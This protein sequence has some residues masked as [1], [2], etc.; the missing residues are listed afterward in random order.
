LNEDCEVDEDDE[1]EL[2][3]FRFVAL[4]VVLVVDEELIVLVP[5]VFVITCGTNKSGFSRNIQYRVGIIRLFFR[6]IYFVITGEPK[7]LSPIFSLL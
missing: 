5:I 3:R 1:V 6:K 7:W 2:R 4:D